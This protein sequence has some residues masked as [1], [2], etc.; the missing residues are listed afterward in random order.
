MS[1][2]ALF[3][4]VAKGALLPTRAKRGHIG[5]NQQE[6]GGSRIGNRPPSN[7]IKARHAEAQKPSEAW[8]PC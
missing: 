1:C 8:P 3:S 4:V 2:A 6:M 5:I 7:L